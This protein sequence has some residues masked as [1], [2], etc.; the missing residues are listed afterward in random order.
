MTIFASHKNLCYTPFK[1]LLHELGFIPR[2]P[3]V[4]TIR[5]GFIHTQ[6]IPPLR[7][8]LTGFIKKQHGRKQKTNIEQKRKNK[9]KKKDTM[10][11]TKTSGS[12]LVKFQNRPLA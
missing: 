12:N 6:P 10:K 9:H 1:F 4:T 7:V 8:V 11:Q 2:S 5:R 3:F